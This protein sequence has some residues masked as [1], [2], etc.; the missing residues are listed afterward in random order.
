MLVAVSDGSCARARRALS[1]VL[2]YE[3]GASD[4]EALALHLGRCGSC[5]QYAA[6]VSS[7]TRDLRSIGAERRH[8]VIAD[9]TRRESTNE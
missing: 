7:F 8:L 3:A 1:L 2:D 9:T 6:E 4:V 5:R